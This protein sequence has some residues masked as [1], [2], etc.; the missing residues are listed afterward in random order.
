MSR[1]FIPFFTLS[2]ALSSLLGWYAAQTYKVSGAGTSNILYYSCPMHPKYTSYKPGDC[3]SCGMRL[4]PV[5]TEEKGSAGDEVG[6]S[7]P[8]GAL[9][10]SPEK[11]QIIGVRTAAVKKVPIDYRMRTVG[12]VAPDETKIVR[13]TAADGWVE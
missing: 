6:A 8:P 2:L 1:K 10:V 7:L 4:V 3:P 9:S 11:Q 5:Y 13:L 12:R